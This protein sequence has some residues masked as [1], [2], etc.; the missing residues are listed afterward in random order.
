MLSEQQFSSLQDKYRVS[1]ILYNQSLKKLLSEAPNFTQETLNNTYEQYIKF[2][3]EFEAFLAD[4]SSEHQTLSNIQIKDVLTTIENIL[5]ASM[6]SWSTLIPL[7]KSVLGISIEPQK[8]FLK[9][10][11]AI[12]KTY[13]K[14]KAL[15]IKEKFIKNNLPIEGFNTKEKYKLTSIKVEWPSLILGTMLLVI[16]TVIIFSDS[17]HTGMQYWLIRIFASLGSALLVTGIFKGT[18]QAKINIPGIAITATSGFAFF[19]ILYFYNPAKEPEYNGSNG[20][21]I[22]KAVTVNENNDIN[23]SNVIQGNIIKGNVQIGNNITTINPPK[24]FNFIKP[25][26]IEKNSNLPLL[27]RLS[28]MDSAD[29]QKLAYNPKYL[30]IHFLKSFD[31]H[32][33]IKDEKILNELV[34]LLNILENINIKIKNLHNSSNIMMSG[35]FRDSQSAILDFGGVNNDAE[36]ALNLYEDISLFYSKK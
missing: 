8:N 29:L 21:N 3:S 35:N 30:N 26:L 16:S 28:R 13:N 1:K 2:S 11:Q 18:I 5:E 25:F 20:S 4:I 32:Q 15:T 36:K 6:V 17:M 24:K 9:T 7:Y 12:L 31:I 23:M 19:L 22:T 33:E 27:D 34:E 10:A 14:E